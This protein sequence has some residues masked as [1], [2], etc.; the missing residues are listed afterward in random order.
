MPILVQVLDVLWSDPKPN[1]GCHPNTFR[2][3]GSYF[4]PDVTTA[5]LEKHKLK[6][7]IRSHECKPDG[8]EYA[9]DGKVRTQY[10]MKI[11]T[12]PMYGS[13]LF[14]VHTGFRG[15]GGFLQIKYMVIKPVHM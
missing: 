7:L 8:Y 2:G 9:H 12:L 6:M 3:G 11:K 4:G 5:F 14:I 1:E 13:P 10:T 15:E